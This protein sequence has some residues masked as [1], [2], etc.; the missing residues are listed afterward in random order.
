[1]I[2]SFPLYIIVSPFDCPF[3]V[4]FF[5]RTKFLENYTDCPRISI[6]HQIDEIKSK[7]KKFGRFVKIE[8]TNWQKN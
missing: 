7:L 3:C 4:I 1:M 2:Q 6:I 8:Y 5:Q